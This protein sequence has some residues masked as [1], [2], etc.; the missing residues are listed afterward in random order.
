MAWRRVC[1]GVLL[2]TTERAGR[3]LAG[4]EHFVCVCVRV[5]DNWK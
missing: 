1:L 3:E 2:V 4:T 5:P